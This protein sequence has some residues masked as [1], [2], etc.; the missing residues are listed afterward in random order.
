[1]G[2]VVDD[3][4]TC[5]QAGA[6]EFII[7]LQFQEPFTGAKEMPGTAPEIRDRAVAGGI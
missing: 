4:V 3:L 2:Q 7:D 6:H 5:A 1:V